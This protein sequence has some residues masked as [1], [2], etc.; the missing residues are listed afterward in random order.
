MFS[1]KNLHAKGQL[2][3]CR[4]D[5]EALVNSS[6]SLLKQLTSSLRSV[7]ML[8]H[9]PLTNVWLPA[10]SHGKRDLALLY[11]MSTCFCIQMYRESYHNDLEESGKLS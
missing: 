11:E 4:I 5:L 9:S 8:V 2:I 3:C 7:E 10:E 6:L 1:L